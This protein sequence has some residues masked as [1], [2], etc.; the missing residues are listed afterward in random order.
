MN[1]ATGQNICKSV[2]QIEA[3]RKKNN[4]KV[5]NVIPRNVVDKLRKKKYKFVCKR[6]NE[7]RKNN[8]RNEERMKAMDRKKEEDTIMMKST[9]TDG[10]KDE[11]SQNN[12]DV[13]KEEDVKMEEPGNGAAATATAPTDQSSN[14]NTVVKKEEDVRTEQAKTETKTEP[15]SANNASCNNDTTKPKKAPIDMSPLPTKR[16][17]IDFSNKVYVAPLTTVG[18]LPFRRI[19]KK[20]GADITCGEMKM[21]CLLW[22][23]RL[24]FRSSLEMAFLLTASRN[25]SHSSRQRKGGS[26]MSQR[27]QMRHIWVKLFSP[28]LN[29]D[30]S[31]LSLSSLP[32][33]FWKQKVTSFFVLSILR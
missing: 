14:G 2:E 3:L 30:T 6:H 5:M 32:S 12:V 17:I 1:L 10:A 8:N 27:A 16:K 11:S 22:F 21:N 9:S 24:K 19:M 26:I 23:L 4:T 15:T 31:E 13:K 29:L 33:R 25:T 7:K 28:P 18:N 20:F